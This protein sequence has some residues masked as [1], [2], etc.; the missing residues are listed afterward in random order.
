MIESSLAHN[1]NPQKSGKV[2]IILADDHPLMRQATRMWLEKQQDLEVIAEACDGKEA[3]DVTTRLNPDILI[4]DI[5]MPKLNGLEVTKQIV[6][7]CPNTEILVLTIHA[8]E[9][10]VMGM[11]QAGASGYLTKDVPGE[12]IVHAVRAIISGENILPSAKPLNNLTESVPSSDLWAPNKLNELTRRELTILKLVA[13]GMP[14]KDIA[15]RIGLSLR[16]T[17]AN[18]T[19]IFLKM[20]VSSRT[21][22]ISSGLKSGLIN[23]EDLN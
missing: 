15:S 4:L 8:D 1:P 5:S 2:R 16:G 21:E 7:R 14:N 22:A 17:K 23:L 10:H 9:E 18:L 3:I 19:T 6:A 13:K 20:G 11:L 12:E